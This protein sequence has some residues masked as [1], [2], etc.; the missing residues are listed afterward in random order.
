M[1]KVGSGRPRTVRT[2]E[3]IEKVDEMLCSQD[4]QPGTGKSRRQLSRQLQ[5]SR[6]SVYFIAKNDLILKSFKRVGVQLLSEATKA[7]RLVRCRALLTR[8]TQ[9][10]CMRLFFTDEKVVYLDPPVSLQNNRLLSANRK[11]RYLRQRLL[12]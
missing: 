11:K 3:I 4:D 9:A 7:K 1:R 8:L 6:S 12:Q 2:A 10:K 5:I